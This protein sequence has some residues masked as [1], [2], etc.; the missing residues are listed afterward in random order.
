MWRCNLCQGRVWRCNQ[1]G[2]WGGPSTHW[3][4]LFHP[5]EQL[6]PPV[7]TTYS[8]HWNN[9]RGVLYCLSVCFAEL[10]LKSFTG[11]HYKSL[12]AT[13][14]NS[15]IKTQH[16]LCF[17]VKILLKKGLILHISH[18]SLTTQTPIPTGFVIDVTDV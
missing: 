18:P 8:P 9:W 7:G 6:I 2:A 5:M 11:H 10:K 4:I 14:Q 15:T 12:K 13:I 3:N 16:S 17:L 1:G